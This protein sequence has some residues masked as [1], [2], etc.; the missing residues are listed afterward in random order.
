M[1]SK[2]QKV[3]KYESLRVSLTEAA[4]KDE[5]ENGIFQLPSAFFSLDLYKNASLSQNLQA[6]VNLALILPSEKTETIFIA[7]MHDRVGRQQR[8]TKNVKKPLHLFFQNH[9]YILS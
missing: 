4:I 5:P 9:N 6:N 2:W 7:E 3:Y 8:H 1:K